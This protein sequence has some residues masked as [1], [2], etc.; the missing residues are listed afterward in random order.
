[1]RMTA[2][3]MAS[4]GL[5]LVFVANGCSSHTRQMNEEQKRRVWKSCGKGAAVGAFAGGATGAGIGAAIA[6]R[7]GVLVGALI[8]SAA[9]ALGGCTI[10]GMLTAK[11]EQQ[12]AAAERRALESSASTA[13]ETTWENENGQPRAYT[14]TAE[15]VVLSQSQR[16]CRKLRGSLSMGQ[17]GSG[18]T[19]TIYCRND[20]GEWTPSTATA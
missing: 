12:L 2:T 5:V 18:E 7:E 16:Q 15:P 10:A 1:M 11:D 20:A 17:D 14:V 13:T 6:G 19:E 8:G 4:L 3:N 9:G